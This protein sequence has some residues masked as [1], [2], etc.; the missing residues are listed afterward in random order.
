MAIVTERVRATKLECEELRCDL[1]GV[2][3]L[4]GW[5]PAAGVSEPYEV[6]LRVA[7]RTRTLRDAQRLATEVETLYTN[8][9][10]GGGGVVKSTRDVLAVA[11]VLIPRAAAPWQIETLVA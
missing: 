3:S 5:V 10:A 2:D 1:I 4:F 6:R 7:G 9:P 8:G 11:S